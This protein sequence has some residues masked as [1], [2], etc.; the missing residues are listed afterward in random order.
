MK[1]I[2]DSLMNII[3]TTLKSLEIYEIKCNQPEHNKIDKSL[4]GA[5]KV[6][7]LQDKNSFKELLEYA[8]YLI[9]EIPVNNTQI[10]KGNGFN[11]IISKLEFLHN[12]DIIIE[13]DSLQKINIIKDNLNKTSESIRKSISKFLSL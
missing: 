12:Q 8:D 1:Q 6:L 4:Q 9:D 3:T 5:L 2:S 11:D 10:F 7:I 13:E